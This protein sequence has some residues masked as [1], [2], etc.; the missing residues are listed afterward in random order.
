[1]AS[2][3]NFGPA[4][5]TTD[6]PVA[7]RHVDAPG[8]PHGRGVDVRDRLEALGEARAA[9]LRVDRGDDTAVRLQEVELAA[10]EER[11]GHVGRVLVVAEDERGRRL[12]LALRVLDADRL[13]RVATEAARH[14]DDTVGVDGRG[15][16]VR[17]QA[18]RA[19]ALLAGGEVVAHHAVGPG[20]HHLRRALARDHERGRPRGGLV[21][22]LAPALLAARSVERHDEI[23]P[24]VVPG[25]DERL[26]VER[27]GRALAEAVARLHLP[28]LLLPQD[29]AREVER[30]QPARAVEGE[31]PLAVGEQR[32]RGVA[33][34][35]VRPLVRHLLVDDGAPAHGAVLACDGHH[36]EL[37][38]LRVLRGRHGGRHQHQLAPHDR[39][40][41]TEAGEVELPAHVLAFGP[42]ERGI[43]RRA[44]AGAER[45]SP[46]GPVLGSAR[47][48]ARCDQQGEEGNGHETRRNTRASHGT[49]AVR[50]PQTFLSQPRCRRKPLTR[51]GRG[52]HRFAS[53]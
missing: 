52:S 40:A 8:G 42:L 35:L 7:P 43:G 10:I 50:A 47:L 49:S 23:G 21:A 33:V 44:L 45:S 2:T 28:E 19:P 32:G 34:R 14:V 5:S 27:R 29:L 31:E 37:D 26:A 46:L 24:F 3:S 12:Y 6:A 1:M 38:R 22:V 13:E 17:R 51:F 16:R 48:G 20:H 36:H 9:V 39:A 25:D 4:A 30:V 11:R 15:D 53:S 18:A 41:V